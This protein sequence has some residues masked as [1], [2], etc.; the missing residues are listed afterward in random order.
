METILESCSFRAVLIHGDALDYRDV[1]ADAII[2]DPPYGMS[3][4]GNQR[5]SGGNVKRGKGTKHKQIIGD[6][7]QFDPSPWLNRGI[8]TVMWG[9]NHFW[10]QLPSGA[11]L[12]WQKRNEEALGS[13]L[14]DGEVA[15]M[16][17]GIGV[18]ICRKV[19]SGSQRAIEGGVGPYDGSLHPNQ[20]P[21][22]LMS[23]AMDRAKIAKGTTV[24]DP[25]MGSGTTGIA[26]MRTGRNFIGIEKD[27]THFETAVARLKREMNQGIL[28]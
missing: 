12:I 17:V 10:S 6:D 14:S 22:A 26:C 28:L 9:A 11:A 21:V 7:Q 1:A 19:F 5:F 27:R 13:F 25:Y 18:Y 8:P 16:N 2:T 15:F 23:W 20:K 3:W 4:E 24:M